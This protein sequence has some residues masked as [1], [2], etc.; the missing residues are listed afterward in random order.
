M[1]T[2][3]RSGS[4]INPRWSEVAA[5]IVDQ[6]RD[7]GGED[8]AKT[9]VLAVVQE[10]RWT[11]HRAFLNYQT[12][13]EDRRQLA[14]HVGEHHP[15]AGRGPDRR[16]LLG[17]RCL[18]HP[19]ASHAETPAH[20][21]DPWRRREIECV[22]MA[23]TTTALDR[24]S[25]RWFAASACTTTAEGHPAIPTALLHLL[26]STASAAWSSTSSLLPHS[27]SNLRAES[28]QLAHDRFRHLTTPELAILLA[29]I[30]S[31]EPPVRNR[32]REHLAGDGA[33]SPLAT[34][35]V[36]ARSEH[37]EPERRV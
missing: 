2:R 26:H 6:L 13:S 9:A 5:V 12:V 28:V 7:G 1:T 32:R 30:Q 29:T 27:C 36:L 25:S 3:T 18:L 22:R 14:A 4:A 20:T 33:A 19:A 17:T 37:V 8:E 31:C 10:I 34:S 11:I 35:L 16:R 24:S 23:L 15:R 21:K